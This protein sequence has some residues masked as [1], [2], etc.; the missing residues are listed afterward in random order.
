M[1]KNEQIL[2]P[3]ELEIMRVLWDQNGAT[4]RTVLD[5]IAK[6]RKTAYTTVQTML[7]IMVKK[8]HVAASREGKAH[9]FR[10]L[11]SPHQAKGLAIK[12]LAEQF[13]H[14]S[15][16]ALA[17]HVIDD[18]NLDPMQLDELRGLIDRHSGRTSDE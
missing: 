14:S 13:F 10:P 7:N 16:H 12:K 4:A 11:L 9:H 1:A 2:T 18:G 5:E 17:Q 6:R 3:G 8:G 15:T